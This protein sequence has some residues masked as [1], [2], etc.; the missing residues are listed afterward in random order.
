L[1]PGLFRIFMVFMLY[2]VH[3]EFKNQSSNL[4]VF[5]ENSIELKV[6]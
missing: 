4:V 5:F 2:V 6:L 3:Y 1:L